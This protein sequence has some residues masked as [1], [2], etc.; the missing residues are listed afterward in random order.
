MEE[1]KQEL[2]QN[3][4]KKESETGQKTSISCQ[5]YCAIIMRQV[6]VCV[7]GL[8][9]DKG[10]SN[11][12]TRHRTYEDTPCGPKKPEICPSG[13]HEGRHRSHNAHFDPEQQSNT[14]PNPSRLQSNLILCNN[15]YGVTIIVYKTS[16]DDRFE[17]GSNPKS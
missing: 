10:L 17:L 9:L 2:E 11:K 1:E 4:D 6:R 13:S 8:F 3:A 15:F 7:L 12:A 5:F 14:N 16:V